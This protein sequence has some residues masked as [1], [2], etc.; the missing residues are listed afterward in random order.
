M[1]ARGETDDKQQQ[2]N[3]AHETFH[4]AQIGPTA[5]VSGAGPLTPEL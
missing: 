4:I 1:C 2:K 3:N 5:M